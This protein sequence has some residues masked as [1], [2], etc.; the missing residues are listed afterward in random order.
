MG[1]LSCLFYGSYIL[2]ALR[3]VQGHGLPLACPLNRPSRWSYQ[4]EF[5]SF[6]GAYFKDCSRSMHSA[7]QAK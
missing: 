2:I 3:T 6:S 4:L 5:D 7:A 1:Y